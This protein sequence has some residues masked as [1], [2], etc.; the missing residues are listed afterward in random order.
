M[1]TIL[2]SLIEPGVLND[3]RVGYGSFS[4]LTPF[5]GTKLFETLHSQSRI[6]S[7]D[8]SKYDGA[9]AVFVPK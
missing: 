3:H 6:T 8:W 4:A 7:Y 9:T 5:P 1:T 2:R